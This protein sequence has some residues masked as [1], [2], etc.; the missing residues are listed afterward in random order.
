MQNCKA[1]FDA[2]HKNLNVKY[3]ILF[4]GSLVFEGGDEENN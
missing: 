1:V 3:K 2:V 4:Y